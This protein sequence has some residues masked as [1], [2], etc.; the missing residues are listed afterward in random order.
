MVRGNGVRFATAL[1]FVTFAF[2]HDNPTADVLHVTPE[3]Y[4]AHPTHWHLWTYPLWFVVGWL[5]GSVLYRVGK[6]LW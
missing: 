5:V 2:M 1:T 3:Y 4:K 6:K